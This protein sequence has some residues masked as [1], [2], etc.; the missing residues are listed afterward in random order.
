MQVKTDDV[1]AE[2]AKKEHNIANREAPVLDDKQIERAK[3]LIRE[4]HPI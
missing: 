4:M 3:Q 1:S 2:N